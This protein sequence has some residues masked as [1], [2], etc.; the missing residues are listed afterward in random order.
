MENVALLL[1]PRIISFKN[2]VRSRDKW[3]TAKAIMLLLLAVCFWIG[4]FIGVYRVLTYFQ[5]IE[6]IGDLL[7]RR[8]LS[9]V[10][11]T[12]FSILLFSNVITSLSTFYLSDDLNLIHSA[13]VPLGKIY[14]ARFIETTVDSSWMA[15]LFGLPVFIAY[16]FVYS[17]SFTYYLWLMVVIIPFLIIPAGLGIILTMVLVNIFP[18]KRTKDIFLLLSIVAVIILYL[19]FRFLRPEKLVDPETFSAVAAYLTALKTPS[20][21]FLP[22]HWATEAILPLLQNYE[23]SPV[24][25]FL[26]LLSTGLALIVIGN[27]LSSHLYYDGWSKSQEAKK[28]TISKTRVIERLI[29]FFTRYFSPQTRALMI[30][31]IK[32]FFR[33]TTQWSQLFLLAALVVVYLYNFSVLP[34]DRSPIPTFY[35]QNLISFLNMGLA[36]FVLSAVAARFAFPAV[37][38]EGPSFWIIGTSPITIRGFL[39]S[40]FFTNLLPLLVLA[41]TII[42]LSNYLLKV[43]N[44][45][46]LLSSLTVFFMTFGII[47]IAIGIGASYPRFNV[48][49][50]AKMATSFGGAVYMICSMIFIGLIVILEAWPVYT[51]FMSRITHRPLDL[52]QW[53]AI[54]LSF[55]AVGVINI[56][57]VF[58]PMKIG[59]MKLS[60]MEEY[61]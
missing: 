36:G 4:I 61:P 58:L 31:D 33:D 8:L 39:W 53:I 17:A 25:F 42:I 12:F 51:V 3:E 38:L 2:R 10:F 46:M 56:L 16:G 13:P 20:S 50:V 14:L 57:A 60:E 28:S 32:T 47:G 15:L 59:V 45:M 6:I 21:P 19:L 24:F 35:L 41:E 49:N 43:S 7:T 52:S 23:G 22:N 26:L 40:K 48:E 11:L 27:Y 18:A 5:G 1:T 55:F 44:F 34:L 37:S 30:K 54:W 29:T 9:M